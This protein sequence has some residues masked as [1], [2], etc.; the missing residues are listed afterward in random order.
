MDLLECMY[1]D[2]RLTCS[3]FTMLILHK[4]NATQQYGVVQ[5]STSLNKVFL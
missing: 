1:T 4:H 3:L 5:A 2:N